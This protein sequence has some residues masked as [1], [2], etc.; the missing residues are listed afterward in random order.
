MEGNWTGLEWN[1]LD[2]LEMKGN[3]G[4]WREM[5]GNEGKWREGHGM[6]F[7]IEPPQKSLNHVGKT[8]INHPPNHH[9]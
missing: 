8:I 1:G 3:E 2:G 5:K 4:K 7:Q 6:D 9:K